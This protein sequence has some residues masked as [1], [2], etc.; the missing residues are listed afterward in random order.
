M[1]AAMSA[2]NLA[3]TSVILGDTSTN[4]ILPAEKRFKLCDL[5]VQKVHQ[6]QYGVRMGT[7]AKNC[8]PISRD[9]MWTFDAPVTADGL[10]ATVTQTIYPNATDTCEGVRVDGFKQKEGGGPGPLQASGLVRLGDHITHIN[11]QKIT[12]GTPHMKELLYHAR[13]KPGHLVNFGLH[14]GTNVDPPSNAIR[15]A[16]PLSRDRLVQVVQVNHHNNLVTE[17]LRTSWSCHTDTPEY[18]AWLQVSGF[19]PV[20]YKFTDRFRRQAKFLFKKEEI[21]PKRRSRHAENKPA[22]AH[23]RMILTTAASWTGKLVKSSKE[24]CKKV[25]STPETAS[26]ANLPFEPRGW[27]MKRYLPSICMPKP[28]KVLL[29]EYFNEY[30]HVSPYGALLRLLALNQYR[31]DVF[32]MYVLTPMRIK[33]FFGTML[34][35]KKKHKIAKNTPVPVIAAGAATTAIVYGDLTNQELLAKEIIR[36]GISSTCKSRLVKMGRPVLVGMLQENDRA[37]ME[38]D[39]DDIQQELFEEA[40]VAHYSEMNGLNFLS[41]EESEVVPIVINTEEDDDDTEYICELMMPNQGECDEAEAE[42][43]DASCPTNFITQTVST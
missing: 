17:T 1:F 42:V 3:N 15:L 23:R 10:F 30:P 24:F 22:S 16:S 26:I 2:G 7:A 21:D 12:G 5:S 32:V 39:G 40:L 6:Y 20:P 41:T 28:M 4:K 34:A 19:A 37:C 33:G 29:L 38:G 43:V 25:L 14:A 8:T 35:Y 13:G 9:W 36:R 31:N 11:N 27:M 18:V